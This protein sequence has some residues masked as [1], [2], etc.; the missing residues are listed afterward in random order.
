MKTARALKQTVASWADHVPAAANSQDE[1]LSVLRSIGLS[2]WD[3]RQLNATG[4]ADAADAYDSYL[5]RVARGLQDGE[6]EAAMVDYLLGAEAYHMGRQLTFDGRARARATVAAIQD[7]L[8][9]IH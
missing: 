6:Q 3:P 2:K 9:S 5:L 1:E 8:R 4:E 7:Y